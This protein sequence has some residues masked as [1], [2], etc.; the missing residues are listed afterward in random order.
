MAARRL[1]VVLRSETR[2]RAPGLPGSRRQGIAPGLPGSRQ[3]GIA[4]GLLRASKESR[5]ASR[6]ARDGRRIRLDLS[7]RERSRARPARP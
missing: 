4:P 7:A 5:R 2:Q 3:Q 1:A 6:F